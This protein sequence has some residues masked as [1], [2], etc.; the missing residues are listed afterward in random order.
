MT[1]ATA[2]DAVLRRFTQPARGGDP[3]GFWYARAPSTGDG[4]GG[5]NLS[6]ISFDA[7]LL[8]RLDFLFVQTAGVDTF[9]VYSASLPGVSNINMF[10]GTTVAG[11]GLYGLALRFNPLYLESLED[12][13]AMLNCQI[14]NVNGE[15]QRF[16]AAGVYW[17]LRLADYYGVPP[18]VMG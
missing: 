15:A 12:G 17:D 3:T 1:I 14:T 11:N 7:R 8:I 16:Q 4:S 9:T 10:T 2:T 5:E 13:G 18:N 6:R